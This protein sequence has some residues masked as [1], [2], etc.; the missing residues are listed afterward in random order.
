MSVVRTRKSVRKR[1]IRDRTKVYCYACGRDCCP[2]ANECGRFVGRL[3]D[4][5]E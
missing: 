2:I 4:L 1:K 5:D 3:E